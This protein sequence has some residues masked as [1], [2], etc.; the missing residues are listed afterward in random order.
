MPLF[1]KQNRCALF[2]HIPKAGGTAIESFFERN[3]FVADLLD[4]GGPKSLNKYRAC[5][6]QHMHA[7]QLETVLRPG[8]CQFVFTTVREPLARIV[9][10]YRMRARAEE[11]ILPLAP[12]LDLQMKRYMNDPYHM[13]NHLRPQVEFLIPGCEVFRQEERFGEKLAARIEEKLQLNLEHR[14][15]PYHKPA[16]EKPVPP[17]QIE[18]I[19]PRIRQIY[20]QDY[21]AFGYP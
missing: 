21:A 12:W 13:E 8:R 19:R 9:S 5:P 10:E 6:P 15:F 18:A 16:G 11:D 20:W 14:N 4:T 3:G 1:V 17:E 2:I 7:A